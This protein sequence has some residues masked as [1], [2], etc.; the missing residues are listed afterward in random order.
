MVI[1]E[2]IT[3]DD[4]QQDIIDMLLEDYDE[5]FQMAVEETRAA[6]DDLGEASGVADLEA[7]RIDELRGRMDSM[8]A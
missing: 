5:T 8:R 3:L 2:I 7:E 4:D 6:M 1:G